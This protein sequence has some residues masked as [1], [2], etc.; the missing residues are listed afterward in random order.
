MVLRH[1][2]CWDCSFEYRRGHGCVSLVSV[3]CCQVE[4]SATERS[5]VQRGP[6][7]CGV[8]ECDCGTSTMRKPWPT[9]TVEPWGKSIDLNLGGLARWNTVLSYSVSY[10]IYRRS[11]ILSTYKISHFQP[12]TMILAFEICCV[13]VLP[14]TVL[15]CRSPPFICRERRLGTTKTSFTRVRDIRDPPSCCFIHSKPS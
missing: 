7:E 12:Q 9:R 15:V 2:A 14:I 13:N 5:L 3:M 8:S 10:A 11:P 4:V 6:T 1:L